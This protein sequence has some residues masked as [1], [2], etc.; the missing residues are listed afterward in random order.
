MKKEINFGIGFITG[1]PNICR[2]INSYY[3]YLLEQVENYDV[4]INFTIFILFDL[5]YQYT[6]RIDFYGV[7]P[8]VYKNISV[9][10]ITP[11]AIEEDKKKLISK[12]DISK[13]DANLLLGK[14]YAKARNTILYYALKRNIDY[15]LF[16][17]DDEYPL[18]NIKEG[19]EIQWIKQ[20]DILE[21]LQNI[22]KVD[23][24]VGYRCGFMTPLPY[25]EYNENIE[26]NDYKKFID[27]L[28]NEVMNWEKAKKVRQEN[29]YIE[30]AN[31]DI[32][33]HKKKCENIKDI[34]K[35]SFVLGSGM[36]LN[37]KRLD[38]IPA[39]YNPPGARGED[40]FFSCALGL[41]NAKVLR[42]PT[43]HFHDCFLKYTYLMKERYPKI[44][45]RIAL[46]DNGIEQRFLKTTIGWT[47]YKP[48]LYYLIDKENYKKIIE[49]TRKNLEESIPKIN[50][51]FETC[52]FD[53][54]LTEL[55]DYNKNVRKHYKEFIRTTEIWD[56]LKYKIKQEAK[57]KDR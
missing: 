27:G 19:K 31:K 45:R 11:E 33:D 54:L 57:Q 32:I 4:K 1:R 15:L 53:C 49:N 47:K 8:E 9:K 3:K 41:K 43:Y 39:F 26:E 18:A 55:D 44:L 28:S 52:K 37:L 25:I 46:D 22:S 51:A 48:L 5:T 50:T 20:P 6:T 56:D 7:L 35:K 16:W 10:Y 23:V 40:T 12:Y 2:I 30:Y 21:H 29:S 14:G 24:T 34:G 17:D 13:E 42:V 38:N 36:C